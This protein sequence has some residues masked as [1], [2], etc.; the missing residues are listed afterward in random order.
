MAGA[1]PPDF[2]FT[3][4]LIGPG[5]LE[6]ASSGQIPLRRSGSAAARGSAASWAGSP[7]CRHHYRFPAACLLEYGA[8]SGSP[9]TMSF[10]CMCMEAM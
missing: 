8:Q 6:N 4:K 5:G 7:P 3:T 2:Q 9:I 1:A 10:Q